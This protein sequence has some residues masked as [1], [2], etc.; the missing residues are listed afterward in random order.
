[1]NIKQALKLKNKLVKL[2]EENYRKLAEYNSTEE[3]TSRPY[4][5]KD[6]LASWNQGVKDLVELKTR[7]HRANAPVYDKIFKLAELKSMVS[8]LKSINC[9]EGKQSSRGRW[10][11]NQEPVV[12][13]AEIGVL[14]R[15]EM[16][17]TLETQIEQ[18]Q[19]ELDIHNANTEI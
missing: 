15:D 7:I 16:V 5:P 10:G 2:N 8:K 1:M 4:E 17:K 11:E 12:Y 19:D 13:V 3:G 9:Q 6:S 18:I 14:Q